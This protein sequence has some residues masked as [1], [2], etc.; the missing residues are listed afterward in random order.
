ME[1]EYEIEAEKEVKEGIK[2][3]CNLSEA[4]E[5]RGIRKGLK[6]GQRQGLKQGSEQKLIELVCRKIAKGKGMLLIAEELEE[7]ENNI[8]KIYDVALSL[9]PDFNVEKVY[10]I[11]HAK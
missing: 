7:D 2:V 11:L 1:E 6:R 9:A 3:M 10:H 4:I 5:E 8:K